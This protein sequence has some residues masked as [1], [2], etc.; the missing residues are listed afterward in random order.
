[1]ALAHP[2][3]RQHSAVFSR[4]HVVLPML[5]LPPQIVDPKDKKVCEGP[6]DSGNG[7]HGRLTSEWGIGIVPMR[8][9]EAVT[10]QKRWII[11]GLQLSSILPGKLCLMLH[12]FWGITM[13]RML[14]SIRAHWS[15]YI[16]KAPLPHVL[17]KVAGNYF[18]VLFHNRSLQFLF[19]FW[20][21]T[22]KLLLS[23][24][25]LV[26]ENY[27]TVWFRAGTQIS[28]FVVYCCE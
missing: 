12:Y 7:C 14:L 2:L 24:S 15:V 10:G 25:I 3:S 9:W 22:E 17:W 5:H 13:R 19:L 4:L 18:C 11:W 1:M 6:W 16:Q 28:F 21:F 8:K 23:E 27:I 20:K 26:L